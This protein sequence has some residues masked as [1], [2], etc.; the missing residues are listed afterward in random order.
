MQY[1]LLNFFTQSVNIEAVTPRVAQLHR[2]AS[3]DA[4][5]RGAMK[6][7]FANEGKEKK[8]EEEVKKA[9]FLT[10]FGPQPLD[11]EVGGPLLCYYNQCP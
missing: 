1:S 8:E 4:P 7:R 9:Q 5:P 6:G 2:F 11:P 10:G 3:R